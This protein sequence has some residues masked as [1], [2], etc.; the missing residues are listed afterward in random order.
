MCGV[1]VTGVAIFTLRCS[2]HLLGGT[3]PSYWALANA[4]C[5]YVDWQCRGFI[6]EGDK[7]LFSSPNWAVVSAVFRVHRLYC[8]NIACGTLSFHGSHNH[9]QTASNAS[10]E[11]GPSRLAYLGSYQALTFGLGMEHGSRPPS[12]RIPPP[13]EPNI[14]HVG[15]RAC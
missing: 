1:S 14:R 9:Q 3:C 8:F 13:Y 4:F 15:L 11:A 2:S 12:G 10:M 7:S 6:E 5:G